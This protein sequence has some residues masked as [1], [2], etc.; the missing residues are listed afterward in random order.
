SLRND[1]FS[2]SQDADDLFFREM[3]PSHIDLLSTTKLSFQ[4]VVFLGSGSIAGPSQ[5]FIGIGTTTPKAGVDIA[6]TV[7]L[8]NSGV[9][10]ELRFAEPLAGGS[11][12]TAF[13]AGPQSADITYTLPDAAPATDG[14]VLTSTTGGTL[15][16]T[17]PLQNIIRGLF[18]PV[19]GNFVHVIPIG[20]NITNGSIPVLTMVNPPGTTIGISVTAIDDINDT[21][22]VETSIPLGVADKIAWLMVQPF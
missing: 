18:T 3:F 4:L 8:S 11:N 21:I 9:P 17:K 16:W 22:T 13:R 19:V 1:H 5:G 7:L 6:K 12:Y 14:Q 2:C 20:A 15:T 10:T